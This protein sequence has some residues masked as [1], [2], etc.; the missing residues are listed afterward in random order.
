M[1]CGLFGLALGLLGGLA[2]Q[3]RAERR[4]T[5]WSWSLGTLL[6]VLALPGLALLDSDERW[7]W[8]MGSCA[9]IGLATALVGAFLEQRFIK[10]VAA[11]VCA[12]KVP[13]IPLRSPA[14]ISATPVVAGGSEAFGGI[15]SSDSGTSGPPQGCSTT[16]SLPSLAS[17]GRALRPSR[18]ASAGSLASMRPTSAPPFRKY[19][20]LRPP[21]AGI[22]GIAGIHAPRALPRVP[23]RLPTPLPLPPR[24]G[25][26]ALPPTS[27]RRVLEAAD[28]TGSQTPRVSDLSGVVGKLPGESTTQGSRRVVDPAVNEVATS[29]RSGLCATASGLKEV[30]P[31]FVAQGSR[32]PASAAD[33][34][35]SLPR[36]RRPTSAG[37]LTREKKYSLRPT[38]ASRDAVVSGSSAGTAGTAA[39]ASLASL[40]SRQLPQRPRP[41]TAPASAAAVAD[42]RRPLKTSDRPGWA[43][44]AASTSHDS[45]PPATV[46]GRPLGPRPGL[47]THIDSPGT[48]SLGGHPAPPSSPPPPLG[49]G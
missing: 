23:P 42:R 13:S 41:G 43:V 3:D 49:L 24:M 39:P 30:Q 46:L 14:S 27:D 26:L 17:W 33:S 2:A 22:A 37:G 25:L 1:V 21:S 19:P 10:A 35:R 47:S 44:V 32:E 4:S 34:N 45:Q 40:A 38:S 5:M 16:S 29:D 7:R 12:A 28:I 18:P 31:E 20:R 8:A 6:V 15:N 9:T 11:Q 36:P 48:W